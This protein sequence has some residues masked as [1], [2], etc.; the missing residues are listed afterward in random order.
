M[1][2]YHA[3]E[4]SDVHRL[5]P[6]EIL[7]DIGV[8]DVGPSSSAKVARGQSN[9][10][11]EDLGAH[12]GSIVGCTRKEAQRHPLE[13]AAAICGNGRSAPAWPFLPAPAAVNLQRVRRYHEFMIT[14]QVWLLHSVCLNAYMHGIFAAN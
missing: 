10:V 7:A 12:L 9:T 4:L 11:V 8:V 14:L 2:D 5:L 6:P 3:M 13:R 1:A